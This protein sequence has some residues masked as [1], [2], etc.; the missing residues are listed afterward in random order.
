MSSVA[1]SILRNQKRKTA[2]AALVAAAL[3][4]PVVLSL[5]N[6]GEMSELLLQW[7]G[8]IIIGMTE[9]PGIVLAVSVVSLGLVWVGIG[10]RCWWEG[11]SAA[12]P[13]L[14]ALMTGLAFSSTAVADPPQRPL[15]L[16]WRAP[17]RLNSPT[18]VIV[19]RVQGNARFC[20]QGGLE[21]E[22]GK[23]AAIEMLDADGAALWVSSRQAEGIE[24]L[25]GAYLHWLDGGD[26]ERGDGERG[27]GENGDGV[28]PRVLYASVPRQADQPGEARL[29]RAR[30]GQLQHVIPNTTHFGNNNSLVA[31]LDGD[32][33][34][35]LIYADQQTLTCYSLPDVQQQWRS[36]TGVLFCWSLPAAAD[37]NGDGRLEIVFGSEYDNDD[38]SSSMVAINA[39]G[40]ELWKRDGF[41]ED[42]GSTPVFVA[43][44]DGDGT[45]ELLKVGLDLEHRRK[46]AWNHLHVFTLQGE[47]LRKIPFGSTGV[48]LGDMDGD[49]H[50]AGVGLRNT[51]DGGT[52]GATAIRAVDLVTGETLWSTP[53]PRAYLDT[54]SPLMADVDGD[55]QLEAVVGTGNPA[56]YGRLPNSDPWGDIYVV[57]PTG[58]IE[59][60]ITLPGWPVN[61]AFCDFDD[62]GRGE[63]AVVIDGLPGWLAVYDTAART[64]LT[65]WKTPLGTAER[66][67]M[68][69]AN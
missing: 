36:E 6:P 4:L 31:D 15:R 56:G 41:S 13:L 29:V 69:V 60:H 44:I 12:A 61:M 62:D 63:L 46:Q 57:G 10:L 49:G 21:A 58:R 53:V 37:L 40:Q 51:R 52:A 64:G 42:L 22:G 14:A 27:D 38:G 65:Q 3:S 35:E 67:G 9:R 59:Q 8:Q 2:L 20:L 54:N 43:D 66:S 39:Q 16:R 50:W 26:G 17:L 34:T 5:T 68:T 33:R 7:G 55:G 47:L 19:G 48:A 18:N 32:G 11:K 1:F 23:F 24:S 25:P 45:R 28:E 30:D